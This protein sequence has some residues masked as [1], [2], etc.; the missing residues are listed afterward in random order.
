MFTRTAALAFTL[1]ATT[2]TTALATVVHNRL[3]KSAPLKD[4][5][6]A[7][8][9]ELKFWFSE[10]PEL[11]LTSVALTTADGG[12]VP[13]GKPAVLDGER[14]AITVPVAQKLVAGSYTVTWKT[15][16]SDGHPLRG[17]FGFT[18]K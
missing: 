18:V 12:A 3:L 6:V 17:S 1:I 10:P 2:V 16:G 13:L 4:E 14:N 5:T 15:V 11:P 8:P 9:A 7:A